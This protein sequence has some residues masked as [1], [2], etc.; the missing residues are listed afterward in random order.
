MHRVPWWTQAPLVRLPLLAQLLGSVLPALAGAEPPLLVMWVLCQGWQAQLSPPALDLLA[1]WLLPQASPHRVC[2]QLVTL[3]PAGS[4]RVPGPPAVAALRLA[5]SCLAL[6]QEAVE[7]LALAPHLS[8]A[9]AAQGRLLVC[10]PTDPPQRPR[11][12]APPLLA[13][14]N[15]LP[16]PQPVALGGAGAVWARLEGVAP[17]VAGAS[18]DPCH[19]AVRPV[20]RQTWALI[21]AR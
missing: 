11:P 14:P 4:P 18:H 19:Q 5:L 7:C 17:W 12:L 13:P 3:S 2:C 6:D 15:H 16:V 1:R 21:R 20:L 9:P 8:L 10:S